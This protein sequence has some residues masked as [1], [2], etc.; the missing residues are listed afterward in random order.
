MRVHGSVTQPY[1]LSSQ[2]A[3]IGV[4]MLCILRVTSS[5]Q[6]CLSISLYWS[7]CLTRAA[8]Y[9][10]DPVRTNRFSARE[11]ALREARHTARSGRFRR[12][13]LLCGSEQHQPHTTSQ[14]LATERPL[15]S[16]R[17]VTSARIFRYRFIS[18]GTRNR[19]T[20]RHLK[21]PLAQRI[22]RLCCVMPQTQYKWAAS[23]FARRTSLPL[24][25]VLSRSSRCS[26]HPPARRPSPNL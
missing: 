16:C 12:F 19:V 15:S 11:Q 3:T 23:M 4:R 20:P 6:Q 14:H 25:L 10:E 8:E 18:R 2:T 26:L 17:Q 21:L 24:L 9:P 13:D 5:V 1:H 7:F 22:I